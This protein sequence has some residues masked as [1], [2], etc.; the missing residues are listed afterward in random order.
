MSL[1]RSGLA[2]E[3]GGL[4]SARVL[5]FKFG[6]KE[7]LG[8]DAFSRVG[9]CGRRPSLSADPGAGSGELGL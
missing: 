5:N 4:D 7:K 8:C 1:E 2:L 3:F 6:A 9:A